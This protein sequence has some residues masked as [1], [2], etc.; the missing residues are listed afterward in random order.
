MTDARKRGRRT[1]W[2]V[3][4]V[5]ALA[6][7]LAAARVTSPIKDIP[8]GTGYA[9]WELCTR[10]FVGG[11]D[12]ERVQRTYVEPK[13]RQLKD[14]WAIA[15]GPDRVEVK[16]IVPTLEHPRAAIFRKGLG[17]TLVTP[18]T[19]EAEVRAQPFRP[20]PVLAP[21]PRPWPLGEAAAEESLLDPARRALIE[22][23]ATG[24]FETAAAIAPQQNTIAL[25]VAE[26]GHLVYER[27]ADGYVRDQPQLGWSMTKTLTA[28]IAGVFARDGRLSIDKPVGLPQWL[29]TTK[30]A[31]KW[32]N[33]LNMAPGLRWFEGYGGSSDA[34]D[35]LFSHANQG[36]FT[37]DLPFDSK[38][39]KVFTYSTGFS[40][41]AMLR[42]KQ[43][44]GGSHQA[45]YDY[46]QGRL[47]APLGIRSG[48]IEPDAS[49]TPVGGARGI[50]RP[51]DWLR[52]GQLVAADGSWNGQALIAPEYI[53]FLRAA[54]PADAGYGGSIWRSVTDRIAP[55]I[56]RRLPKDL[57]FFA[58]HMGQFLIVVPS[59][60]LLVLRMG[61]AFDEGGSMDRTF[62]LAVDLLGPSPHEA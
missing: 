61:V 2:S 9:A 43:L 21:D 58:G 38:P 23:H 10:S 35:M 37:A 59:R 53:A 42:M 19:T 13:V 20:A 16:T 40:N 32:R 22:R 62:E 18:D 25:L 60:G 14:V 41:V 17:C 29:G 55:N 48:A 49:G 5:I 24:L 36:A 47:F 15:H 31:I 8:A 45:L 6:L 50:L 3:G 57:V 33:L 11:Q 7:L 56:R 39:G 46:Y 26:R 28:L 51:V 27:Y 34:T 4:A 30:H 12:F 1:L 52:L 44:L 54:S